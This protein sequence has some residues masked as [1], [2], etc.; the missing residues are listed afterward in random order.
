MR[1]TFHL[2][3]VK[4]GKASVK[5]FKHKSAHD[6]FTEYTERIQPFAGCEMTGAFQKKDF[7]PP[8]KILVCDRGSGS[9]MLSSED[10]A[11]RIT[12]MEG[13]GTKSLHV[14]IGGPDG[15]PAG[16]LEAMQPELRWC[17]G[18]LTL[19]HELA[20]VVAAEQL[21]RAF[22]IIKGLPYHGSH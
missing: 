16:T 8:F 11:R 18:P 21:Y 4:S 6:L 15:F 19:P 22:S 10:L 5:S 7:K 1:I 20:A 12:Q 13:G 2:E 17:F 14:L 9:R 3:W